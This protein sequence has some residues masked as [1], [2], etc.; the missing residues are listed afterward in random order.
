MNLKPKT[1]RGAAGHAAVLLFAARHSP[2]LLDMPAF[3]H[4]FEMDQARVT[5]EL[6][7]RIAMNADLSAA[8][9][10]PLRSVSPD[11]WVRAA[12]AFE[13]KVPMSMLFPE[14]EEDE[15]DLADAQAS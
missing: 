12:Q 1:P 14:F 10:G 2:E 11:L 8:V 6:A 7:R 5:M 4:L 15:P 3:T 9:L 13:S